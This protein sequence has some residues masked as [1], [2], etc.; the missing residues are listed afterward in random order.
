MMEA[1]LALARLTLAFTFVPAG[2]ATKIDIKEL[3]GLTVKPVPFKLT[4]QKRK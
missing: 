1:K 3:A 4:P 2:G